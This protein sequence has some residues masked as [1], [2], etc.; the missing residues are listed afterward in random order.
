MHFRATPTRLKLKFNSFFPKIH[1]CI[2][3]T[4]VG[5][6]KKTRNYPLSVKALDSPFLLYYNMVNN[7]VLYI[8]TKFLEVVA[9]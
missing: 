2:K 9:Y 8:E 1:V 3:Y 4:I 7:G 5:R 6:I